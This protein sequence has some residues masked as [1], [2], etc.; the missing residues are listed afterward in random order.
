MAWVSSVPP[1]C[2]VPLG[3]CNFRHFKLE[4]LLNE[5]APYLLLSSSVSLSC[6]CVWINGR[7]AIKSLG[8]YP[9]HLLYYVLCQWLLS[10]CILFTP[11]EVSFCIFKEKISY[12]WSKVETVSYW[13][14][15]SFLKNLKIKLFW[16]GYVL[17]YFLS[18]IVTKRSL[19][20]ASKTFFASL[21]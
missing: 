8:P 7:L 12:V 1:Q 17:S 16:G 21:H 9:I 2:T 20:P 10:R 3:T 6:M 15:W 18:T 11:F 19:K 4:F 14:T 5:S 13:Q